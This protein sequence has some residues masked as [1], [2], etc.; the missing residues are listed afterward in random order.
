MRAWTEGLGFLGKGCE[1]WS[2]A[3]LKDV[4]VLIPISLP[5]SIHR[6]LRL[7]LQIM[8][9]QTKEI[10]FLGSPANTELHKPCSLLI[11]MCLIRVTRQ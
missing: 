4:G 3:L 1:A 9:D 6:F 7:S 5:C 8:R 10:H 2:F 11:R